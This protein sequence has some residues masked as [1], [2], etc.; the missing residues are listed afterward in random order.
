MTEMTDQELIYTM[1]LT[2]ALRQQSKHQRTLLETLGSATAVYESRRDL[3]RMF[4][5]FSE[6]MAESLATMDS[7]LPR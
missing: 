3:G 1:A 7:L 5:H 2:M 6:R 4:E